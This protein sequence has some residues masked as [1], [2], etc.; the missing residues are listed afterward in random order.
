MPGAQK[1]RSEGHLRVRRSDEEID[2][3]RR[4]WNFYATVNFGKALIVTP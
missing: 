3:E 1:L 4:R 2:G